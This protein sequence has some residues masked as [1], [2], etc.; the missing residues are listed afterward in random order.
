MIVG[1]SLMGSQIPKPAR[2]A[3]FPSPLF[4]L[5]LHSYNPTIQLIAMSQEPKQSD[6]NDASG[7]S[8]SGK[9]KSKAGALNNISGPAVEQLL[10]AN[11]SLAS[12]M[13]GMDPKK[14]EEML[15]HMNLK[16]IMTGMVG[17]LSYCVLTKSARLILTAGDSL[18]EGKI[19]R[20][21]RHTS[22]G[23]HSLFLNSVFVFPINIFLPWWRE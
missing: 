13:H 21:W 1:S 17:T 18:L 10:K 22:S 5:P 12:E 14:V 9:G 23:I 8:K 2:K 15:K 11:P 6:N 3:L 16:D 7:G 19:K 20:I 4:P